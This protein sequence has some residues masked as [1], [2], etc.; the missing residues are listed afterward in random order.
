MFPLPRPPEATPL[1]TAQRVSR[2]LTPPCLCLG[3]AACALGCLYPFYIAID[4]SLQTVAQLGGLAQWPVTPGW[5]EWKTLLMDLAGSQGTVHGIDTLA[6]SVMVVVVSLFLGATAHSAFGGRPHSGRGR[7]LA[8]LGATLLPQVALLTS[9][10]ELPQMMHVYNHWWG[11]AMP[12]LTFTL[13]FAVWAAM[14][15]ADRWP[16]PR[17]GGPPR[18][19]GAPFQAMLFQALLVT[20]LLA[21]IAAWGEFMFAVTLLLDSTQHAAPASATL[22]PRWLGAAWDSSLWGA[23]LALSVVVAAGS[24]RRRLRAG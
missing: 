22:T 18:P 4:V 14:A 19:S 24:L 1:A 16:V 21:F 11:L 8:T 15:S 3:V 20:A 12:Y 10:F 5:S 2:L 6:L 13:P 7:A 23:A 17:P 9:L